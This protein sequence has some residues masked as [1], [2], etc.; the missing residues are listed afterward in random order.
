MFKLKISAQRG[1]TDAQGRPRKVA[2]PEEALPIVRRLSA[3][4]EL[5][6]ECVKV[7]GKTFYFLHLA[8]LTP[9]LAGDVFKNAPEFPFW[10]KIWEASL[11]LAEFMAGM[12]VDSNRRILEV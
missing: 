7:L 6:F 3:G 10:V 12:P 5:D 4:Y 1:L 11:V 2:V 9:L 8:D